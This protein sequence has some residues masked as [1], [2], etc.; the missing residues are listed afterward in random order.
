M[1]IFVLAAA[2]R[3]VHVAD[4]LGCPFHRGG[5][6]YMN[7][8]RY[9]DLQ[10]RNILEGKRE[11]RDVYFMAPLYPYAL[12][13]AYVFL[14]EP[15]TASDAGEPTYKYNVDAVR[16]LQAIGG[17]LI[18]VLIYWLGRQLAGPAAGIIAGLIAVFYGMFIFQDGLL[19]ATQLI[20]FLNV[21]AILVLWR[22]ARG[23]SFLWWLAGGAMLG[24]CMVG[25]GTALL[26]LPGVVVW[27]LVAVPAPRL[28]TRLIRCGGV[29]AGAVACVAPVTIRNYVVGQD[30]VLLTANAGMN[31]YIGNNAE[32]TGTFKHFLHADL[33]GATLVWYMR[34]YQRDRDKNPKPSEVSRIIRNRAL[35]FI[36]EH[37]GRE[38]GLLALKFRL[39]WN[40]LELGIKDQY[41]FYKNFAHVLRWPLPTFGVLAPLGLTGVVF[42]LTRWRTF[43]L[44]YVWIAVQTA[45]FTITFVLGRY[46]LVAVAC[47]MVFAGFQIVW[48]VEA[49][50]GRRYRAVGLSLIPLV[51][52]SMGVNWPVPGF[53]RERGYG[54]QYRI[55]AERTRATGDEKQAVQL[56]R[57]ALEYDFAPWDEGERRYDCY[58]SLSLL[59]GRQKQWYEVLDAARQALALVDTLPETKYDRQEERTK[60]QARRLIARRELGLAPG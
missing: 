59:C 55:L 39:F 42:S 10:A 38:L 44:L 13:A 23:R 58:E 17:A 6:I 9:Y 48:W 49:L 25:H 50:R 14:R 11:W 7:D 36:R 46:R 54:E 4:V 31:F 24:I 37:P 26:L 28:R 1:L 47:L 21:V 27:I 3:I 32:A 51:V 29:V 20:T 2:V 45:A 33:P 35:A 5:Y 18:C 41:Y 56:Y 57:T 30:W 60:L 40:S 8:S 16:Y 12:A 52:F 22:A 43:A 53:S 34:G 19:L 15:D